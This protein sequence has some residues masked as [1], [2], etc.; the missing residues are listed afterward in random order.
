VRFKGID[1]LQNDLVQALALPPSE[2]CTELGS[3]PCA[4]AHRIALGGVMPYDRG[5][6]EPLPIRSVSSPAAVDRLVLFAC[7]RRAEL[8]FSSNPALFG[9]LTGPAVGDEEARRLARKLH[10]ALLRRDE[11]PEE[12]AEIVAFVAQQKAKG[13][14]PRD[15]AT[16]SCYALG[17]SV[18]A[19][20]Y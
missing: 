18:E 20:F 13:V 12:Q 1:R 9:D 10:N 7:A 14:A 4:A 19:L 11:T 6:H 15:I 2:L 17:T 8:D 5:I 16:L 3:A